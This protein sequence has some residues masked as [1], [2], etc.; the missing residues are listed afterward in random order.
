MREEKLAKIDKW[1]KLYEIVRAQGQ[2]VSLKDLAIDGNDLIVLGA[3]PG[4]EIGTCLQALLEEVLE[5]PD[6]NQREYLTER[7]KKLLAQE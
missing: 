2:C 1:E 5:D 3:K 4:R 7:A 6:R